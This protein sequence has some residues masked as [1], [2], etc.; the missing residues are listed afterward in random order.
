M[1]DQGN[2]G[3]SEDD[4]IETPFSPTVHASL[5]WTHTCRYYCLRPKRRAWG[6]PDRHFDFERCLTGHRDELGQRETP[7][8]WQRK[9]GRAALDAPACRAETAPQRQST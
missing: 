6:G 2:S 8:G 3:E 1:L 7:S 5:R 9:A 4:G